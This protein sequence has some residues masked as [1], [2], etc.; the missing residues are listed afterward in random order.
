MVINTSSSNGGSSDNGN[1]AYITSEVNL[2]NE[3]RN[4]LEMQKNVIKTQIHQT[5]RQMVQRYVRLICDVGIIYS[6]L[7]Y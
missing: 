1:N 4:S 3:A 7:P 2:G 5:R 6:G